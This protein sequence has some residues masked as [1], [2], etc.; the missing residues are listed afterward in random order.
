MTQ[1]DPRIGPTAGPYQGQVKVKI[2]V[3][4]RTWSQLSLVQRF[5]KI[6][7]SFLFKITNVK[8]IKS[9]VNCK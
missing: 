5:T 2:M 7:L 6:R 4:V 3:K 8:V 9:N 1:D